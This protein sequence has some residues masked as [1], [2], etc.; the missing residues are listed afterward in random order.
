LRI[1]DDKV[2]VNLRV[3][4]QNLK[5]LRLERGITQRQL[6]EILDVSQ[7]FISKLETGSI[8]NMELKT[9]VRIM[10]ALGASLEI[11]IKNSR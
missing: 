5:R 1:S 9:L 7:P 2:K 6:A 11:Q 10:T 8:D 3:L 4:Q